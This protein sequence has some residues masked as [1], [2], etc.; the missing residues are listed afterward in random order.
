MFHCVSTISKSLCSIV[1]TK[2]IFTTAVP[3]P[4]LG[5]MPRTCPIPYPIP[6]SM[7]QT[8]PEYIPYEFPGST[9]Y[10]YPLREI[11]SSEK[12]SSYLA[13]FSKAIQYPICVLGYGS[14]GRSQA[15]NLCDNGFDVKLGLRMGPSYERALEDGW[16][17]TNIYRIDEAVGTSDIVINL[18]SHNG[19]KEM[20]NVINAN[21][22]IRSCLYFS[23]KADAVIV[24]HNID[25]I[26]ASP[27]CTGDQLRTLFLNDET[28]KCSYVIEQNI[29]GD[30]RN[31]CKGL[32]YGIG[33]YPLVEKASL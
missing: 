5:S 26:I 25:L 4:I 18:L 30:A 1:C 32:L 12:I 17:E 28:V 23:N 7:P 21:M 19:Q 29:T 8:Y 13:I 14:M 3:Y 31:I 24:P 10:P 16:D 27:L 2:S 11:P 20:N 22:P 33:C 6:G 9:P 15:M